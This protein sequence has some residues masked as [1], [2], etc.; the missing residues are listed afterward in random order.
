MVVASPTLTES[1]SGSTTRVSR[2]KSVANVLVGQL[3]VAVVTAGS[4]VVTPA[5]LHGLGDSAY[6]GW[7]LINSFIGYTKLLDLGTTAGTVKY[8]A[9]AQSRGDREDLARV[10][11]TS[12]AMFLAVAS[13]TLLVTLALAAVLPHAYASVIPDAAWTIVILGAGAAFDMAFR[14]FAS[15]LRMRSF[16]FVYDSIEI[17]TYSIFKLGLLLW[18]AY[19]WHLDYRILAWLTF[20]E[21]LTRLVAVAVG[22]AIL[23]PA[24]RKIN[25]FR[26]ARSMVRKLA[27]M[28]LG[29]SILQIADILRFQI[30]AGVIGYLLPEMPEGIAVFGVG[31]RLTSIAYFVIGTVSTVLVPRFSGLD[32]TNDR[33]GTL[34]LLSRANLMTGLF[35]AFLLVNLGVFGPQFLELWLH[36]PWVDQSGKIMRLLIPA[37]FVVSL[38]LP[39][40]VMVFAQGK[41]R[42]LTILNVSEALANLVLSVVLVRPLGLW[43]VAVGTALPLAL[44]RGVF[45]PKVLEKEIGITVAQ[46][47]RGHLTAL[48]VGGIYLLLASGFCFL[49][50]TS[51]LSFALACTASTVLFVVLALA[52]V[53]DLR[54]LVQKRLATRRK[55]L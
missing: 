2:F 25:P 8:G 17:V 33:A 55:A 48:V 37:Y 4:F 27:T 24:A 46:Y 21:T 43:G 16:Y 13:V 14:P 6:G 30:D 41:L 45:F 20:G 1:A 47:W 39:S 11:N 28:G 31:T 19:R 26:P 44:F 5:V 53:P 40:A 54:V 7:L 12:M 42:G 15:A 10:M 49:R 23:N 22:A 50:L 32:E 51:I 34:A 9:G 18:C 3:N 35:A 29:V 36:K 52:A 38:S